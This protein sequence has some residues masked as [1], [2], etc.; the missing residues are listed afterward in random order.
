MSSLPEWDER[1]RSGSH[2]S[3]TSDPLLAVSRKYW[4]LLPSRP[5]V[6]GAAPLALDVACGAGRHAVALAADG[7]Q[8]TAIDFSGEGLRKGGEL[9]AGQGVRVEW[10]QRDLEAA[11]VDLGGA[12][13]DLAAVFFYLHRPLFPALGRCLKPGGLL[14]YKTYSVDQLRYPGRPNHRMHM[15]EHNELLRAFAGFRVLVYEE[16]WEGKGTA[17]LIAQKP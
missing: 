14:V 10:V 2:S 12:L 1:F 4:A 7:F 3:A 8:V 15:L 16:E 17:S 9:A 11:N 5:G 6:A 13:Y